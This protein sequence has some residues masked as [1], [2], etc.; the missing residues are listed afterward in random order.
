[1]AFQFDP[2]LYQGKARKKYLEAQ[3]RINQIHEAYPDI[4]RADEYLNY[5]KREYHYL[6]IGIFNKDNKEDFDME[7]LKE[8][9]KE[10]E[11]HF[12]KLLDK[13]DI[14][15]NYKEPQWDC[16]KCQDQGRIY[17]EGRYYT[18]SCAV[19]TQIKE[20][21]R[22]GGLPRHLHQATFQKARMEYYNDQE[23]TEKGL[24]YR[25]N[26][27]KIY[28]YAYNFANN[29]NPGEYIR[30]LTVYGPVGS[31]KSF[32]LGCIANNLIMRGIDFK[33][34]VYT[35]LLQQIR[36]TYESNEEDVNEKVLLEEVQETPVLLI[37]D[38]GTEK[39]SEF[40][41]S[42][43]Y[44]IIDKRYREEKPII[45]STNYLIDELKDRFE[46]MF[47]EMGER[48]FQRLSEMNRYFGLYGNVRNIIIDRLQQEGNG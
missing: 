43:L 4:K 27:K 35:D 14:P 25:E 30:G 2:K 38:L 29:F 16:P 23:K 36:N 32:L 48:I 26:A 18:C 41:A 7:T 15:H 12:K 8:E 5:L 21:Q 40:T 9:I 17:K 11:K 24:T 22:Q 3:K 44:Q 45:L 46:E 20:K 39:A 19:G 34:I 10:L 47:E 31:G 6:K 13:N 33:Y 42:I 28:K 1:M 37:D